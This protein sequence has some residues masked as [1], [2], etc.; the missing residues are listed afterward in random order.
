MIPTRSSTGAVAKEYRVQVNLSDL[1][2][3]LVNDD[4]PI[5]PDGCSNA[6]RFNF[7]MQVFESESL[8]LNEKFDYSIVLLCR[9]ISMVEASKHIAILQLQYVYML[10][11][12]GLIEQEE[13]DL[14]SAVI[15]LA[16][17]RINWHLEH[18]SMDRPTPPFKF[19]H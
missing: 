1:A 8:N 6:E 19:L 13:I 3:E 7:I 4:R 14:N 15:T 12:H 18:L 11:A 16:I 5:G 17:Q 2:L 10:G 9:D